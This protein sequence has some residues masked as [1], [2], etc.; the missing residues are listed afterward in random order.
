MVKGF[1]WLFLKRSLA[2]ANP[3]ADE[4]TVLEFYLFTPVSPEFLV[5]DLLPKG[6]M[7]RNVEMK[8]VNCTTC[9]DHLNIR[10]SV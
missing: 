5:S 7:T 8:T 2:V 1:V 4:C 9:L 3:R 10:R 6:A